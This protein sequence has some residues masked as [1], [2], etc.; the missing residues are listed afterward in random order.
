MSQESNPKT[1][2]I[3]AGAE[4]ID[5]CPVC[6]VKFQEKVATNIKHICPNP[7]CEASFSIMVFD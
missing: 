1:P 7:Q 2:A 4:I 5:R 3:Q 6:Q